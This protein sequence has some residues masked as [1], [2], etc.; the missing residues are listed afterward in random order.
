MDQEEE[1]K[2]TSITGESSTRAPKTTGQSTEP[3]KKIQSAPATFASTHNK[4]QEDRP[5]L[6]QRRRLPLL[7]SPV[8]KTKSNAPLSGIW[9]FRVDCRCFIFSLCPF[10][11][12]FF[13]SS[14][15]LS[16]LPSRFSSLCFPFFSSFFSHP[17]PFQKVDKSS[18]WA[19][20]TSAE[21]INRAGQKRKTPSRF[22]SFDGRCT[23]KKE[24][25]LAFVR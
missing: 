6:L 7:L 5:A 18:N 24:L 11:F 16:L 13:F 1:Q 9:T 14:P 2:A 22:F 23:S 3:N 4:S 15:P 19:K 10:F 12:F 25:F 21:K 17:L 8:P 20:S